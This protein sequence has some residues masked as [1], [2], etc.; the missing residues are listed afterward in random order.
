MY[1][2]SSGAG[3]GNAVPGWVSTA[4]SSTSM[5]DKSD[6]S[7][8][9]RRP[10]VVIAATGAASASMNSI[11]AVGHRRVDRQVRRPGLEH[12][13][14]RHDRLGGPRQQQRHT[15]ARARALADQQVRQ[16]VRRPHRARDRSATRPSHVSA[17]ASGVAR[18][19]RGEQLRNRRPARAPAAPTP[20]GCPT[21]PAGRARRH[22]ADRSTTTAV[23]GIG[24]H[25]HQHPLEP[26]D[27]R[28]RCSPRRTPRCRIRREDPVR[29]PAIATTDSG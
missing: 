6:P 7:S 4:G 15:L 5:T 20:P 13:Q 11:R 2:M 27:Q 25:G 18:H 24:G 9:D 8:R 16:P 10:A 26:L 17:T 1:A 21:H 22:R 19:L 3:A 12:R 14:D 29:G 28:R 23:V